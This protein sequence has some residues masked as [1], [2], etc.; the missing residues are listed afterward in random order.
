MTLLEIHEKIETLMLTIKKNSEDQDCLFN[1]E[2]ELAYL[3]NLREE[4]ENDSQ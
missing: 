3:E 4:M 1:C 2:M